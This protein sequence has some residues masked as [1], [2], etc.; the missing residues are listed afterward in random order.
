MSLKKVVPCSKR[1]RLEDYLW[2]RSERERLSISNSMCKANKGNK[3]KDQ[4]EQWEN[5]IKSIRKAA[6]ILGEDLNEKD[7]P[8]RYNFFAA[9]EMREALWARV[10]ARRRKGGDALR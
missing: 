3:M 2:V 1:P 10:K 8:D 7:L 4:D 5:L 6:G 9:R